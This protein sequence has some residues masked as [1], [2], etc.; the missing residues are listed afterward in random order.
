MER[1]LVAILAADV[2]GYSRLVEQ[3]EAGTLAALMAWRKE[4]WNR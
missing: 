2:V 3:D 1:K 4:V